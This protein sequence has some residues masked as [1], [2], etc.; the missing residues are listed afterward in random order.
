[1]RRKPILPGR[2][3][4][5]VSNDAPELPQQYNVPDPELWYAMTTQVTPPSP[6]MPRQR[7]L[8]QNPHL[9]GSPPMKCAIIGLG[10]I[11]MAVYQDLAAVWPDITGVDINAQRVA[12]LQKQGVQ[13]TTDMN[14]C[15]HSDVW[16]ICASTGPHMENIFAITDSMA[17][18]KGA[19]ISIESTLQVNTM[20]ELA[21]RFNARGYRPGEDIFLVHTPHR[22]MFGSN[23]STLSMPRVI[24]GVTNQCLEAGTR[25]YE[26]LHA[27]LLP[28]PDV[29]LAELAKLV[30]NSSRYVE[31]AFAEAIANYCTSKNLDFLLLRNAVNSKGNVTLRNVDYGIGGECLPK[32]IAFLQAECH[33]PLF[34]G[35]MA[36]DKNYRKNLL[37][38][39]LRLGRR[40]LIRGVG[41]KPGLGDMAYSRGVEL[42]RRLTAQGCAVDIADELISSAA[43]RQ[44]GLHPADTSDDTGNYDV[45]VE[46][47]RLIT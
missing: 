44:A 28:V 31:I 26:S 8:V 40:V 25:F 3:P 18:K 46:R 13:A 19:L 29:R 22:I 39:V 36:T 1:M 35:A 42:A 9:G 20:Q 37:R 32:D 47:G 41:Y 30:E 10:N 43:L 38:R 16:I 24:G 45:V 33:S 7:N 11:G 21:R 17:P 2:G 4:A 14:A 27:T 34:S 5:P 12:Y 6:A 23:T 15:A